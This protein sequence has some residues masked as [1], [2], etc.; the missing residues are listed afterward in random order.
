MVVDW[1]GFIGGETS[2]RFFSADL[3]GVLQLR[4]TLAGNEVIVPAGDNP[5][6]ASAVDYKF[7]TIAVRLTSLPSPDNGTVQGLS[8]GYTLSDVHFT[9]DTISIDPAYSMMLRERLFISS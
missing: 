1:T 9:S 4:I 8:L 6:F 7:T 2:T 3:G 5:A